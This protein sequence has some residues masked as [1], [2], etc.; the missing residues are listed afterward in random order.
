MKCRHVVSLEE[1]K[2]AVSEVMKVRLNLRRDTMGP[3]YRSLNKYVWMTLI[4]K[5]KKRLSDL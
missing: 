1:G 4:N 5:H 3:G 2:G